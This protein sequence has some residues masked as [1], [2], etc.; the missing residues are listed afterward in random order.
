MNNRNHNISI[1]KRGCKPPNLIVRFLYSPFD[2]QNGGADEKIDEP[3]I[4]SKDW[5]VLRVIYK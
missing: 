1:E 5:F 3:Q 2:N 4:I